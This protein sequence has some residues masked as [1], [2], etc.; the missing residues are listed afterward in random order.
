MEPETD[1]R[2]LANPGKARME[3]LSDGVFSIAMTLLAFN[4]KVPEKVLHPRN[5]NE[6]AAGIINE[7]SIFLTFFFS[8]VTLG[9]YWISHHNVFSAIKKTDRS[10]LW[11]NTHYLLF[12][13][14]IP[15]ST[16]L[17][18]TYPENPFAIQ[19]FGANLVLISATQYLTWIRCER[20]QYLER[21]VTPAY[22]QLVKLR[23]VTIPAV[24][25]GSIVLSFWRPGESTLVYLALLPLY[26]A[27]SL[28]ERR[29]EQVLAGDGQIKPFMGVR[30]SE[31]ARVVPNFVPFGQRAAS[32]VTPSATETSE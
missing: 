15:F 32:A 12:I 16:H 13:A 17:L 8:F 21:W 24:A 22:S 2:D 23:T 27:P 3:A 28:I 30:I 10:V 4:L 9:V 1:V 14:G 25:F 6:L 26:A 31:Q 7:S 5:S 18:N 11:M 19:L 29:T 20:K